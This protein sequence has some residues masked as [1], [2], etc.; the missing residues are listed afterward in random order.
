[1][2]KTMRSFLG[3]DFLLE[4]EVS[5]QLYE[6]FA[7]PMPILD[8]HNHLS[9]K[10]ITENRKFNNIS[11]AWLAGDHY[12][13]RA[14]RI[15][16]VAEKYATGNASDYDKFHQWAK[17]VPS[18]MR[19]PLYHWTHLELK[20]YFGIRKLLNEQTSREIYDECSEQLQQDDY[21]IQGLLAKMNVEVVC[22]TDDPID[23]LEYHK[24][25]ALSKSKLKMYPSF[26][27]DKAYAVDDPQA[28]RQYLEKLSSASGTA[29]QSFDDLISA[30]EKRIKFFSENGCKA[31]DHGPETL[32]F[33]AEALSKAS[34]LFNKLKEGKSLTAEEKLQYRCAIL[35][36]LC[37]LYHAANWA[38][39][40]HVGALRNN[41]TRMLK[42]LGPDTGF[43]SVG[44]FSQAYHMSRF[45]DHLDS[46]NQLA[47]TIIY[48]LNPSDNEV[49]ATMVG[50][51]SDGSIPGKIQFG[52]GWW[53]LDQKDGMERQMTALSNMGLLSRFIGMVTDSRSFLS[54]PRHEYFRRILCNLIGRDVEK[55]ELPE[56]MSALGNMVQDISYNNAKKYFNF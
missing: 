3:D 6:Q 46:N 26:R 19:N 5:L 8:Y 29:I 42:Q 11:E 12:K 10:E 52:S 13:W 31:S 14:M 37:K 28:Y 49:F 30:L 33:D 25:H 55:G 36:Q 15:N 9:P 22:T 47:R 1:M 39:Q 27:P 17:T 4:N 44:D 7:S 16:G 2:I 56:D 21:R 48:N 51:F 50:N 41:N 18:T 53:F 40:F 24:A 45:F 20:N 43:D 35:I 23:T 34:G 32:Y 38:Q 54:F